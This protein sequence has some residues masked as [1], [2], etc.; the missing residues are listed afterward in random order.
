MGVLAFIVA[1]RRREISVRL[2][3]GATGW[4]VLSEVLGQGVRLAAIGIA[5][6][7][8]LALGAARLLLILLYGTTP[9]DAPTLIIVSVLLVGLAA[10]ASVVPAVR[11]SRVDSLIALREE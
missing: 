8:A 4:N 6:G 9:S 3:L 11:A 5:A 10:L 2:A 7:L 1:Q